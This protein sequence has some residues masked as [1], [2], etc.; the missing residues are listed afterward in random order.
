MSRSRTSSAVVLFRRPAA[1]RA[2]TQAFL[3]KVAREAKAKAK[4]MALAAEK[5][6]AQ[7]REAARKAS[8]FSWQQRRA[9]KKAKEAR[10]KAA[11]SRRSDGGLPKKIAYGR[12]AKA[13]V[14]TGKREKTSGGVKQTDLLK[15]SRGRIVSQQKMAACKRTYRGSPVEAWINAVSAARK[16]LDFKGWVTIGGKTAQGR[17]LHAKAKSIHAGL[18]AA[19]KR[20]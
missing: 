18:K 3:A 9:V 4:A 13:M 6:A 20:Q 5:A 8:A 14:Y 15:N 1:A 10:Q 17:A 7:A 11:A 2:K 12:Y 16:A 19:A